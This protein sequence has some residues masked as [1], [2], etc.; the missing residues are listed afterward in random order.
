M[1]IMLLIPFSDQHT[2]IRAVLLIFPR[3]IWIK[4]PPHILD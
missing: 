1:T 4:T 3:N 2:L